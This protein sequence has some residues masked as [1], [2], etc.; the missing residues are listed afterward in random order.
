MNTRDK[1]YNQARKLRSEIFCI[2]I[3]GFLGFGVGMLFGAFTVRLPVG[4]AEDEY[5]NIYKCQ[6]E[7]PYHGPVAEGR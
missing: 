7:S 6:G 4:H 1:F 5:G 3:G 2:M